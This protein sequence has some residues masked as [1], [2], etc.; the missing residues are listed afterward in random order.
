VRFRCFAHTA[1]RPPLPR[2]SRMKCIYRAVVALAAVA[3]SSLGDHCDQLAPHQVQ[4]PRLPKCQQPPRQLRPATRGTRSPKSTTSTAPPSPAI[5][6]PPRAT[7]PEYELDSTRPRL[8]RCLLRGQ[9]PAPHGPRHDDAGPVGH[10]YLFQPMP[11]EEVTRCHSPGGWGHVSPGPW[12]QVTGIEDL[13]DQMPQVGRGVESGGAL[14]ADV[15]AVIG[16]A[17]LPSCGG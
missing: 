16:G 5:P 10:R 1:A 11:C 6:P 3:T 7:P 13:G 14:G 17:R 8:T 4:P 12:G 9:Y 15:R 2:D